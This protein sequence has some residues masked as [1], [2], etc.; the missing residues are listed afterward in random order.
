MDGDLFTGSRWL[1]EYIPFLS[2]KSRTGLSILTPKGR[3]PIERR[4][5]V[6]SRYFK[7]VKKTRTWDFERN[8]VFQTSF[9]VSV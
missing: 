7:K 8:D 4:L 6:N 9:P 2:S 1:E 3:P 5:V